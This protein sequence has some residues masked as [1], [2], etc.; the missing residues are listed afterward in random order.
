MLDG[1]WKK[2][3][4]FY[5]NVFFRNSELPPYIK[6]HDRYSYDQLGKIMDK[7]DV[8]ITPS[9]WYETFGYTVLEALSYGVP[10]IISDHVGAKDIVSKGGGI[11]FH[12]DQELKNSIISLT[13]GE[14]KE[15]NK[16]VVSSDPPMTEKK[17]CLEIINNGY[18]K[19]A[20]EN[21]RKRRFS[22]R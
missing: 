13:M 3:Q 16:I 12:D 4:D 2:K 15:M 7:S 21:C 14:L 20:N 6:Q 19:Q 9:I 22:I 10:V 5:L 18:K 1:L 8:V 17:M 11:I